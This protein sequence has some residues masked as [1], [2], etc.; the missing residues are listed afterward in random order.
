MVATILP[1]EERVKVLNFMSQLES[2]YIT[3][4]LNQLEET[5]YQDDSRFEDYPMEHKRRF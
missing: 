1:T 2:I 5:E 4:T 3:H